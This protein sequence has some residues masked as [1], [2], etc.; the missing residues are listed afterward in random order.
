[1][2]EEINN[3]SFAIAKRLYGLGIHR[4][5]IPVEPIDP[6]SMEKIQKIFQFIDCTPPN[7]FLFHGSNSIEALIKLLIEHGIDESNEHLKRCIDILLAKKQND[8]FYEKGISQ[9]GR[10]LEEKGHSGSKTIRAASLVHVNKQYQTMVKDEI[11]H[12]LECFLAVQQY[13]TIDDF[14]YEKRGRRVFKEGVLFPDYYNLRLL[15]Y[16]DV[17][18]SSA[19]KQRLKECLHRL[20][21]L[22]PIPNIYIL[23]KGRLIAPGSYLMHEFDVDFMECSDDKKAEFLLRNEYLSRMGILDELQSA[24]RYVNNKQGGLIDIIKRIKKSYAFIQWGSYTGISLEE[25][26]R[27]EERKINDV[28]FRFGLIDYYNRKEIA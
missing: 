26:W 23:E 19:T 8:P 4:E 24:T 10:I 28:A 6:E 13:Q 9:I 22:Q 5:N 11:H 12:S 2:F 27:K 1:M 20:I 14:T 18:K 25:D 21:Q 7:S 17:W 3:P 16:S 15:A